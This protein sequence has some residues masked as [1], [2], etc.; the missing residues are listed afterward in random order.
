MFFSAMSESRA[1]PSMSVAYADMA[2]LLIR[3]SPMRIGRASDVER[4]AKRTIRL[5]QWRG[6]E[7]VLQEDRDEREDTGA[8]AAAR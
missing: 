5:Y 4:I 3:K 1:G 8:S 6:I 2:D 7:G